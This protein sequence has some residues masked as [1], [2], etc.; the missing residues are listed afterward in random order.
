MPIK[1]E[2]SNH[3]L[4]VFVLVRPENLVVE[5]LHGVAGVAPV[6][7]VPV[8][9]LQRVQ[10]P[11]D[12]HAWKWAG[13]ERLKRPNEAKTVQYDSRYYVMQKQC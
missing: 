1:G 7:A 3:L 13:S 4:V 8:Q 6:K 10:H 2:K 5:R 9:R 12:G 11:A